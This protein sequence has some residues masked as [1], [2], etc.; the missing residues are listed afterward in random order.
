MAAYVAIQG[1]K[2]MGAWSLN[3]NSY[4]PTLGDDSRS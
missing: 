3:G 2:D 4:I 1:N